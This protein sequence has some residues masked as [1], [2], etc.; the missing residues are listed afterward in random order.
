MRAWTPEAVD[1]LK[2][3]IDSLRW[4]C[5][6][7]E[8]GRGPLAGPVVACAIVMPQG[9]RIEGVKDSKQLSEKKRE[10]LAPQILAAC[11]AYGIGQVDE[12][13]I[14]RINI[15]Q[16]TLLAMKEALEGL[17]DAAGQPLQPDL[18]VVDAEQVDTPLRQVSLVKADAQIYCVSCASIVAKVYRDHLMIEWGNRF[19]EYQLEKNKGYGTAAHRAAIQQYGL[20]PI[21]RRSFIHG[22]GLFDRPGV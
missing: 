5:G 8:V 1:Q 4:V 10:A 14:D 7:D 9:E 20:L 11:E 16:A 21:H 13:T 22:E 2:A 19:P 6:I 17:R 12:Q 3:E 18:V 15:R